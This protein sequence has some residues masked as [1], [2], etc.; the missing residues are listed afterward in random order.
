MAKALKI[1]ESITLLHLPPYSPE[2]NSIE[3][4]WAYIRSHYLSNRVYRDYIELFEETSSAWNR[5]DAVRLQSVTDTLWLRRA[6]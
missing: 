3:R 2:L 1:P 6:I 5:L 4:I